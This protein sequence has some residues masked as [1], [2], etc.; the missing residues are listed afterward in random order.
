VGEPF[1]H[2]LLEQLP[3]WQVP[4]DWWFVK[5]LAPNERGKFSRAEWRKKYLEA[6]RGP[7]GS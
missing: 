5:S 2:V 7:G 6:N 3:A 4:R 1:K